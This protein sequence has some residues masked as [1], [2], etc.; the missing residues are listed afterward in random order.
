[1]FAVRPRRVNVH[2]DEVEVA[3]CRSLV[4]TMAQGV[5]YQDEK[6][7]I[8]S[9]NPAAERVLGV[10]LGE[11]QNRSL[12]E[13]GLRVVDE[14][15]H[16]FPIR[17]LPY[18]VAL[19]AGKAV[20]DVVIGLQKA[21]SDAPTWVMVNAIPR[22]EG[23]TNVTYNVYTTLEDITER[24][25]LERKLAHM[26][27]HDPLT[28]L[29]N[30]REVAEELTRTVA[31]AKRGRRSA[32]IFFDID[33][34]KKI[35]DRFGHSAGDELL[36]KIAEVI[37]QGIR[38]G[39]VAGRVGGDEFVVIL[40]GLESN[41]ALIVAER[42]RESISR[43]KNIDD[44]HITISVGVAIIDGRTDPEAIVKRA[45]DAMYNAKKGGRNR[46]EL[47]SDDTAPV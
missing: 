45:D 33:D 20:V 4:E 34:L 6:G 42:L 21:G 17:L 44:C 46:V 35:N 12:S 23:E 16:P 2:R 39:D 13:L 5:L 40:E 8:I 37:L 43:S 22:A 38:T 10:M 15:M 29:F 14:E 27:V 18:N 47:W 41:G 32:L 7:L 24:K 28:G 30:R 26:V 25:E 9:A 1:M 19:E 11:M 3:S 36:V 31:R